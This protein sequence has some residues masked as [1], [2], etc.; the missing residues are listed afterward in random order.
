MSLLPSLRSNSLPACQTRPTSRPAKVFR[1]S[2]LRA[3]R[4]TWPRNRAGTAGGI[5]DLDAWAPLMVTGL[6]KKV[7]TSR[8]FSDDVDNDHNDDHVDDIDAWSW[9]NK[10]S[11]FACGSFKKRIPLRIKFHGKFN[12]FEDELKFYFD[13]R[14]ILFE[15]RLDFIPIYNENSAILGHEF[16]FKT[17]TEE[18]FIWNSTWTKLRYFRHT[19]VSWLSYIGHG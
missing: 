19:S 2:P 14:I 10:D 11:N 4:L 5:N 15:C 7:S 1:M 13:A 17:D 9:F 18:I 8:A 6:M 12:L 16:Y 3:C